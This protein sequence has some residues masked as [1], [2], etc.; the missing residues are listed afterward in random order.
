MVYE[1][2]RGSGKFSP[3]QLHIID[4]KKKNDKLREKEE[5]KIKVN[6][7][8]TEWSNGE[9]KGY[10]LPKTADFEAVSFYKDEKF[11]LEL[12]VSGT[13]IANQPCGLSDK[14]VHE[15]LW[16]TGLEFVNE[17][18]APQKLLIVSDEINNGALI[19]DWKD[20][21]KCEEATE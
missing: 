11:T 21:R 3:Q 6:D 9:I 17:L 19:I 10:K 18:K 20:I 12:R 15:W 2:Y 1:Q 8:K 13:A 4:Q 7:I 16:K 5:P 14:N